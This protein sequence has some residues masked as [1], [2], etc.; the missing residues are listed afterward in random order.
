MTAAI[1]RVVACM[2][3]WNATTF[4]EPVLASV[5]AQTYPNLQLLISVD[6]SSDATA[7]MCERFAA[8]RPNVRVIRQSARLGWLRNANATLREARGEY[9]FFAFHDDPLEPTY[10]TKLVAALEAR[11]DAVLAFSDI[12]THEGVCRYTALD[13]TSRFERCRRIFHALDAWWVPNRGL[14]RMSAVRK[15]EGMR[16]HFAGEYS[17][18]RPWLLRLAGLGP[19]AHVHEPLLFKDFRERSLSSTWRRHLWNRL[20]LQLAC[21]GALHEARLPLTQELYLN[22]EALLYGL[23]L[24]S[25]P[26]WLKR[27]PRKLRARLAEQ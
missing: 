22:V 18:D 11:P 12:V 5:A 6:V 7:A 19:F 16:M 10:V 1:P 24:R 4:I 8:E 25:V 9:A 26:D 2:P 3:T 13:D 21:L 27:I 17:A 15:L 20:G 23:G 14:M